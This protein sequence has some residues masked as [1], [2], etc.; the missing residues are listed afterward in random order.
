MLPRLSQVQTDSGDFLLFAGPDYISN[1]LFRDGR[2]EQHILDISRLF[3]QGAEAPLI[4]DIGANLGAYAV[5]VAKDIAKSS[6]QVLAFEP[7][8]IVF[9]QLCANILLN[10][11]DN[12]HAY[13]QALGR[14]S[15]EIDIPEVNYSGNTNIGAFSLVQTYR[16]NH[17]IEQ[18]MKAEKHSVRMIR[19]DELALRK[20]PCLIKMDVEGLEAEVLRGGLRFLADHGYPPILF[21]AWDHDWFAQQREELLA[22]FSGL[23]YQFQRLAGI[24]Y[25]AQHPAHAGAAIELV[26][27]QGNLTGAIHVR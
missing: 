1:H 8:R 17:A 7:Q 10:R 26:Y 19:L 5:P 24:E 4:L 15:G 12:C 20:S 9:Y 27:E 6:G 22:L 13:Q 25:L 21:E 11:L 16:E 23:G 14:E 2:W 18:S 3:Y